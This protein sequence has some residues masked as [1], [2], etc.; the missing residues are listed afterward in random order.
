VG[1][2]SEQ[3]CACVHSRHSVHRVLCCWATRTALERP[4]WGFFDR[5]RLSPHEAHAPVYEQQSWSWSERRLSGQ[6]CRLS[7]CHRANEG[8]DRSKAKLMYLL[9]IDILGGPCTPYTS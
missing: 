2:P 7:T 8:A 4:L 1:H 3:W 6:R 9:A 5:A